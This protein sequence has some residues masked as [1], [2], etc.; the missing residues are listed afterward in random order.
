MKKLYVMIAAMILAGCSS[1]SGAE[2]AEGT[3]APNNQEQTASVAAPS[4]ESKIEIIKDNRT[5]IIPA[6]IEIPAINVKTR[7]EQVGTLKDGRMDVPKD[8]DNVGWY[9]PGTL[10]GAP[11]NAVLAG[12]VD[13]LT[14]PAIF[15]DLHKLKNGDKIM[16]T[17]TDGQTL[18]FEVYDQKTF[19]RLDA[20]IEDIFGFT[21]ASTLNLI[22]CSGDYDPETTERAERT[23]IYTKLVEEKKDSL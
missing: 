15:Y 8:P 12:H 7:I 23:V 1:Q 19:P 14:S 3:Q 2:T 6:T 9:E 22:T 16:L 5:G 4:S 21:F 20:P 18:T 17:D 10:P 11:G 13:D